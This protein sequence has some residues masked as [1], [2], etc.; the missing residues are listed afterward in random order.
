METVRLRLDIAYDGTAFSGWSKQPGLRTV[1]EVIE[2][3][4]ATLVRHPDLEVRLVVAGRTDAGVHATGQVAHIDLTPHQWRAIAAARRGGTTE[5]S[6]T[7]RLN[8]IIS[9]TAPDVVISRVTLAPEGF[10]AR[11]SPLWRR[12]EYRIAD[13]T[14]GH[15]PRRRAHTLWH[16]NAL[17][18]AA[19]DAAA[20]SLRGLHDFAAFCKPREGATTIRTLL[21][22]EWTRDAEGV[23]IAT[24][25]ADAFC[26][27]MVRALV[28][29]AV[30]MGL[31]K[32]E[33]DELTRI[34]NAAVKAN[35]FPVVAA[36]GLT[37]VE[38]AYPPDAEL[39]ARAELT[40]ARREPVGRASDPSD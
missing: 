34:L 38:V 18:E 6:L 40:R 8:G 20:R 24:V 25:R 36:R 35:A 16:P 37:L 39:G 22:Y 27:S 7:R 23:L 17:D 4:I 28:G 1:Q 19:M 10:D 9:A 12:Y 33:H 13:A 26:H 2:D 29:A 31:G 3:A 30:A 32:L 11:F 15:D 5:E 21:D 14:S